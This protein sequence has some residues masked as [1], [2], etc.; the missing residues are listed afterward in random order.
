MPPPIERST[1]KRVKGGPAQTSVLQVK[2]KPQVY[3]PRFLSSAGSFSHNEYQHAYGW[4]EKQ[5]EEENAKSQERIQTISSLISKADDTEELQAELTSLQK[6]VR[7]FDS[8]KRNAALLQKQRKAQ[9]EFYKKEREAVER[10]KR[11]HYMTKLE[12]KEMFSRVK[13]EH[14]QKAKKRKVVVKKVV[15]KPKS[16]T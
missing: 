15:K 10:G 16:T 9:N 14:V 2:A 3:D 4:L 1:K 7:A 6:Q 12:K 13:E 11:P 5:R 8:Q